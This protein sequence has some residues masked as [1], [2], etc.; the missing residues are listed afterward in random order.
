MPLDGLMLCYRIIFELLSQ[1]L[2]GL[3]QHLLLF[4]LLF[5]CFFLGFLLLLLP[6]GFLLLLLCLLGCFL[7]GKLLF[8]VLFDE[9]QLVLHHGLLLWILFVIW[10]LGLFLEGGGIVDI[11]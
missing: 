9:L 5:L 1:L 6:N 8:A 3:F 2:L 10:L 4:L 11:E 7:L